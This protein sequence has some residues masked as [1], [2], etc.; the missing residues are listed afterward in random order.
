M[1]VQSTRK[2]IY[3]YGVV[4]DEIFP[5]ALAYTSRPYSEAMDMR[6]SATYITCATSSRKKTDDIITFVEFEEGN[7]LSETRKDA[8]SGDESDDNS[9]IPP[10]LSK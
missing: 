2:I 5:S 6:P 4:F 1:Y 9:I 10:L 7:L 3:L 8:E